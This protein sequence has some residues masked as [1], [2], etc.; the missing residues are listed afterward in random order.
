MTKMPRRVLSPR[1]S[2]LLV[3]LLSTLLV[4][5]PGAL[6]AEI[7]FWVDPEGVT[8]F[9]D[10]LEALPESAHET[11]D[12]ERLR[13]AWADGI[14]GPTPS[15]VDPGDSSDEASR[16]RRLLRGA[17]G[18][19]QRG[20]IARADATLRGVLRL[21]PTQAQAH[22]YLAALARGRGRFE[23]AERHLR[24]FL[25]AA[26]PDLARWRTEAER[27]LEA[28]E[29]EH[30]LAD[31]EALEGPLEL[32][33]IRDAHFRV[34]V[35]TR[36]GDGAEDYA[37]RVLRFLRDARQEVSAA[38]GVE[39]LEPL[40]VVLYG[41]AAYLRAHAHRF[42]FQT[43]G[44]FDGRIHVASPANPTQSLRGVLFHE[45]THAVFRERT[46]GDRPYWLNEGLAE[47]IERRSR[48]RGVSTRSERAALRAR[49]ETDSWI[50]LQSIA[51]SFSGLTDESARIAYL[52]SVVTVGYL[53][54][55]TTLEQRRTLLERL[56]EGLSADQALHEVLGLDTAGL[57]RAVREEILAE[58]PEWVKP[59]SPQPAAVEAEAEALSS[60]TSLPID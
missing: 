14:T 35:D 21:D 10:D 1:P 29:A 48:G 42:S 50:P 11:T 46:G 40:G 36:L 31:P 53:E 19:L 41:K 22:W 33:W 15:E 28:I 24:R 38:V 52:Q 30:V 26:G 56:G 39:P 23:T 9:T 49:I 43:I 58:F 34:Q 17:L 16:V 55:R 3:G 4:A 51:R 6:R 13:G 60:G 20:E 44:F 57:D 54:S 5:A 59:A 37:T 45:Y 7:H 12:P 27:R 47:M 18:D 2:R 25:D 8:H 32:E